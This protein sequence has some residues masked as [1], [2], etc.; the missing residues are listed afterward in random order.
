M[1]NVKKNQTIKVLLE[2]KHMK[3]H[4][5]VHI[6]WL[7][8]CISVAVVP[9]APRP[10]LHTDHFFF[11]FLSLSQSIPPQS[12]SSYSC[13]LPPSPSA[14]RSFDSS[15]YSSPH[16]QTPPTANANTG[17]DPVHRDNTQTHSCVNCPLKS[18]WALKVCFSISVSFRTHIPWGFSA[19]PGPRY[20]ATEHGSEPGPVLGQ[21]TVSSGWLQ[22]N[23]R[24][25]EGRG[26]GT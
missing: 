5:K 4:W 22:T 14:P 26:E 17:E 15:A 10:L 23:K 11:L 16:L 3:H 21:T 13:M 25:E 2:F 12:A 19:S 24:R 20:R 6:I 9:A 8:W 18:D 7:F 1:S